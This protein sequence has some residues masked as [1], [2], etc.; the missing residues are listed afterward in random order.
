MIYKQV[1]F[2]FPG[3]ITLFIQRHHSSTTK[4]TDEHTF[5]KVFRLCGLSTFYSDNIDTALE[6]SEPIS[7]LLNL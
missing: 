6:V 5:I 4:Y 2:V 1:N 7:W 3:K